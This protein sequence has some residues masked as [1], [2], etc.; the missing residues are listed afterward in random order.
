ME[1][2]QTIFFVL[3]SPRRAWADPFLSQVYTSSLTGPLV[4]KEEFQSF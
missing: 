4:F 3:G 2:Q 1:G